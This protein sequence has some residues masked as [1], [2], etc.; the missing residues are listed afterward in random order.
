MSSC[1][2]DDR[3][4][5]HVR[6]VWCIANSELVWRVRCGKLNE[7]VGLETRML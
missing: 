4:F 6:M 5:Q 7:E 3:D 1:C 2:E